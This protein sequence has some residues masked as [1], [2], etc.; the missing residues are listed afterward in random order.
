M[1][2]KSI[3]NLN[4]KTADKEFHTK[5][6]IV[7]AVDD[8]IEQSDDI[9]LVKAL[10]DD[11]CFNA[12]CQ[13]TYE[14]YLHS[15]YSIKDL[16]DGFDFGTY[17]VAE[18]VLDIAS[19]NFERYRKQWAADTKQ[20]LPQ[21]KFKQQLLLKADKVSNDKESFREAFAGL[22]KHYN[23]D[24]KRIVDVDA[25]FKDIINAIKHRSDLKDEKFIRECLED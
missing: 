24:E 13:L 18:Y 1:T 12:I 3:Y 8:K 5:G 11:D 6:I 7:E 16:P 10:L 17:D 15:R 21:H 20:P 25:E 19:H 14:L 9:E 22:C 2:Y 4:K 23:I